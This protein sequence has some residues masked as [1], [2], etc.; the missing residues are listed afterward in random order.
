MAL[1]IQNTGLDTSFNTND[2]AK[3]NGKSI[4]A[5]SLKLNTT[6]DPI[7]A[8]RESARRQA[9]KL[10]TDAWG[11]DEKV[12]RGIQDMRDEK[13]LKVDEKN[14]FK[15]RVKAI[16]D[17]KA[18][19][20]KEY[21]IADDSEEQKDLELLEKYQNNKNG[22]SFD[23]F[24]DEEIARLKELQDIPLTEY[25]KRALE[26][27]AAKSYYDL[28]ISRR[29]SQIMGMTQMITNAKIEQE[30][31]QDMLKAR[32]GADALLEAA[33]KDIV[34]ML[35]EEGKEH[36]DE[37]EKEEQEKAEKAKEAKEEKEERLEK[38]KEN[39]EEQEAIIKAQAESA[40]LEMST[41]IKSKAVDHVSEAQKQIV[42][43]MKENHM[44]NEDLL[45]IEIDFGF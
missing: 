3:S 25:Q 20:K 44:I 24:S 38:V 5:R 32:E 2:V 33:N 22:S 42:Q 13:Q 4:D 40:K 21:N 28:E 14:E 37:V 10:I 17:G 35:F 41:E 15:A 34:G 26:L 7:Q 9:M 18:S 23:D 6:I 43:I 29:D 45:G 11:R 16:N 30:K 19:L 12:S 1:T 27:N 31:S 8:K 36:I 39:R